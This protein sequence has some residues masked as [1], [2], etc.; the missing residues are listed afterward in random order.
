MESTSVAHF[1][2]NTV[3]YDHSQLEMCT[4]GKRTY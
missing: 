4:I 2:A 1:Q 3:C